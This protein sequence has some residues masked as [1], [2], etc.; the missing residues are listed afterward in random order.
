MFAEV[1]DAELRVD[2]DP[3][4]A[5]LYSRLHGA[6]QMVKDL[7][8]VS[9][10]EENLVLKTLYSLWLA[11]L[12]VRSDWSPAFSPRKIAAIRSATLVLKKSAATIAK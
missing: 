1:P 2:L 12:L 11:G 4:E 6:P 5:F 7:I 3:T 8:D 10:M 9:G